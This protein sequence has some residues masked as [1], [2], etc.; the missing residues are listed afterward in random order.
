MPTAT[1]H[2]SG[3]RAAIADP[4]ELRR[5]WQRTRAGRFDGHTAAQAP[6]R[7]QANLMVVPGALA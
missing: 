2:D 3:L 7:V 6:G 4:A 5:R 1:A